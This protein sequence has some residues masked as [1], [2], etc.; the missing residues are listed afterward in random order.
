MIYCSFLL[1][2]VPIYNPYIANI[3]V[4][5]MLS[6]YYALQKTFIFKENGMNPD[7]KE[8]V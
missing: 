4:L 1:R 3:F 2:V 7:L 6:C 5:K 8:E